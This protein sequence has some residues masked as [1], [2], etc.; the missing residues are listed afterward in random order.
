MQWWIWCTAPVGNLEVHKSS[1]IHF[2]GQKHQITFSAVDI[3]ISCKKKTLIH[4][5][6][7]QAL[8]PCCWFVVKT[9]LKCDKNSTNWLTKFC[10]LFSTGNWPLGTDQSYKMKIKVIKVKRKSRQFICGFNTLLKNGCKPGKY[11]VNLARRWLNQFLSIELL[12]VYSITCIVQCKLGCSLSGTLFIGVR[13][14]SERLW[15][16]MI[17]TTR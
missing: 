2:I 7:K 1:S 16:V 15:T 5:E 11:L 9:G 6:I 12:T 13:Q 17:T 8:K 14:I 10:M 4:L 3:W